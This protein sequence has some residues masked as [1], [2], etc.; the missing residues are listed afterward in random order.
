MGKYMRF[1]RNADIFY[2]LTVA[3]LELIEAICEER[4]YQKGDQ[5]FG[6]NAHS[7]ELYIIVT[8][9]VNILLN[10]KLVASKKES[11]YAEPETIARLR[12]GQSFGEI[13]LV[14]QGIR[15]A[16]AWAGSD[17]TRLLLIRRDRLLLLCNTTPEIGYRIMYNLA[18]DLAQ[19]MRNADL[20]IREALLYQK[21]KPRKD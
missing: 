18:F 21:G 4:N 11:R 8:G 14:D 12:E 20:R 16:S 2:D 10:P 19:K 7:D 17:G 5:I 15:S 9:Q 1:L 13:A 3:Q 6:E